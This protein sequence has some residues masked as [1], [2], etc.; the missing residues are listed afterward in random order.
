M[1]PT[2]AA[3]TVA[4][5]WGIVTRVAIAAAHRLTILTL[6]VALQSFAVY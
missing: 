4:Y 3:M 5:L 2:Q 6:A 1:K